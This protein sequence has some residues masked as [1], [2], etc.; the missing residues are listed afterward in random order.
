MPQL[1]TKQILRTREPLHCLGRSH[2]YRALLADANALDFSL[3]HFTDN[4]DPIRFFK[5]LKKR[6]K[7]AHATSSV[8]RLKEEDR[9]RKSV[10][11]PGEG[12]PSIEEAALLLHDGTSHHLRTSTS[13]A[14]TAEADL[15]MSPLADDLAD[16]FGAGPK[17]KHA[18]LGED[19]QDPK[20]LRLNN[21]I[22]TPPPMMDD[23][24]PNI[25]AR[26][27]HIQSR[28]SEPADHHLQQPSP[29]LSTGLVNTAPAP[30]QTPYEVD[31]REEQ[32]TGM[33]DV[34]PTPQPSG[35]PG[36][37]LASKAA[38]GDV[39]MHDADASVA[40]LFGQ[41]IPSEGRREVKVE[42]EMPD[43]MIFFPSCI[44]LEQCATLDSLCESVS[45]RLEY[46]M[47]GR[48]RFEHVFARFENPA[49]GASPSH[50]QRGNDD[51]HWQQML[52]D[53]SRLPIQEN[54]VLIVRVYLI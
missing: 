10:P 43:K 34:Q 42:I 1:A 48:K 24:I 7:N 49:H 46:L 35:G 41:S 21:G 37:A 15:L 3:E 29:S 18:T 19:D 16:M 6:V 44:P 50:L 25:M 14:A 52:D 5:L 45:E 20:R 22:S 36:S 8:K 30:D 28:R 9:Q 13:R 17:R 31:P 2:R 12:A 40:P 54:V 26:E 33:D 38:P 51:D 53:A 47:H 11:P 23:G 32:D 27:N 39:A 4:T